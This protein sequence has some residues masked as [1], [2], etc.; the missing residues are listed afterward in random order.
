MNAKP[1]NAEPLLITNKE[2][3]DKLHCSVSAVRRL[4]RL[5]LLKGVSLLGE[6]SSRITMAS[7]H[8]LVAVRVR[9]EEE[10]N[11]KREADRQRAEAAN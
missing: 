1:N 5:G 6:T 9:E 10:R 4:K 8:E 2:A 7:L 3:A 11:T